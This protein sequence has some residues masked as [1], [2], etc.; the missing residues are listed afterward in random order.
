MPY[1]G[2]PTDERLELAKIGEEAGLAPIY[3]DYGRYLMISCSRPGNLPANLQGIWNKE[4]KPSW[5][6]KYTI[7]INTEMNYWL[8]ESANLPECHMPL[9]S[10]IQKMLPNGRKVARELYGC[11]GFVAHHN[12]DIFG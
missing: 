4:L 10:L 2:I 9:F 11:H 7:N 3:L 5:E 6:S 12:T 1:K 8:A